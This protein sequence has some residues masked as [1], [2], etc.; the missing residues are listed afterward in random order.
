M[1]CTI[2]QVFFLWSYQIIICSSSA[3]Q[4]STNEK[5]RNFGETVEAHVT[6]GVD[7]RRGDQVCILLSV[8]FLLDIIDFVLLPPRSHF[9]C[10]FLEPFIIKY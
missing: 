1:Q 7:P 9:G 2:F 6:L 8:L 10:Y 3:F 4:A 5:K